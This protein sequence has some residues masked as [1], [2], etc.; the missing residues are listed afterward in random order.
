[1]LTFALGLTVSFSLYLPTLVFGGGRV[2]TLLT[3]GVHFA[4]NLRRPQMAVFAT[5]QTLLSM[6]GLAICF[7]VLRLLDRKRQ[8]IML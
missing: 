8:G 4:T 3:E 7:G 2:T 1:M 6:I 5:A